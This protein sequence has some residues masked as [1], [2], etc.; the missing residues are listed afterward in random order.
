MFF[1]LGVVVQNIA[2]NQVEQNK[3]WTINNLN[4]KYGR[5]RFKEF[6]LKRGGKGE[7]YGNEVSLEQYLTYTTEKPEKS[8]VEHY[9]KA[10][11]SYDEALERIVLDLH[12]IKAP[13][14]NLVPLI[15]LY[16]KPIDERVIRFYNHIKRE[17]KGQS[18]I[19]IIQEKIA[20]IHSELEEK[21]SDRRLLEAEKEKI[22]EKLLNAV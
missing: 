14:D 18:P 2:L 6:Y 16:K 7:V 4:N 19:K 22:F 10:I 21:Y 5:A 9:A 3:I 15:N 20:E 1:Y 11:G 17:Y 13:L 12:R 8:A